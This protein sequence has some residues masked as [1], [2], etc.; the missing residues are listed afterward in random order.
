MGNIGILSGVGSLTQ[1]GGSS[2]QIIKKL[3]KN[4][5]S[6]TQFPEDWICEIFVVVDDS[7]T[8]ISTLKNYI[9]NN[10]A[11]WTY[12]PGSGSRYTTETRYIPA[13]ATYYSYDDFKARSI[14]PVFVS[15]RAANQDSAGL[16][17]NWLNWGN[18]ETDFGSSSST[19]TIDSSW[20]VV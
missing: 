11:S 14:N 13:C 2:T 7:V 10:G 3:V 20:S 8:D 16:N 5:H 15:R 4:I 1:S 19:I 18:V 17:N 6:S 9:I 12:Q